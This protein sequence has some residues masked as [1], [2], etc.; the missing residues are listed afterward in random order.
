MH[1]IL[2]TLCTRWIEFQN[3]GILSQRKRGWR[4]RCE[5]KYVARGSK[6]VARSRQ[7]YI[8]SVVEALLVVPVPY[9]SAG[10]A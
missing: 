10:P 6:S 1:Y 5:G 8:E 9:G 2:E 3:A 4:Q 7:M